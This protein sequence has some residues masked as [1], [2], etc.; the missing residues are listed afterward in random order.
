MER[1]AQV[2]FLEVRS[3]EVRFFE[4]RSGEVQSGEF[5]NVFQLSDEGIHNACFY[6]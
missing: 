2:E 1:L 5:P 6:V 3:L 4:V